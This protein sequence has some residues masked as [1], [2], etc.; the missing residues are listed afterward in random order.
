MSEE[1]EPIETE[2]PPA[3]VEAVDPPEPEVEAAPVE[4]PDPIAAP[5][6]PAPQPVAAAPV[7]VIDIDAELEAKERLADQLEKGEI[8]YAEYNKGIAKHDKAIIKAQRQMVEP[9]KQVQQRQQQEENFK[10]YFR[11]WG[12]GADP[13]QSIGKGY[14]AQQ[15]QALYRKV[16]QDFDADP[17]NQHLNADRE[18]ALYREF[19]KQLRTPPAKNTPA[20]RATASTRASGS[21]G[22]GS[23]VTSGSAKS[24]RQRWQDGEI[25]IG[26]DAQRLG[27]V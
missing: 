6:A 22:A 15:A 13:A 5:S 18:H 3:E 17:L 23:P 19:C 2:D 4:E 10:L 9:A 26:N 11:N 25:D 12:K 21:G 14:T 27:M 16:E 7:P 1:A 20:Q 8:D 24:A